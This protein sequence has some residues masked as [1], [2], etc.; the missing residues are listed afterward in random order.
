MD[1]RFNSTAGF[2]SEPEAI[3]ILYIFLFSDNVTKTMCAPAIMDLNYPLTLFISF[4]L[5]TPLCDEA[6]AEK[7]IKFD[8]TNEEKKVLSIPRVIFLFLPIKKKFE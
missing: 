5:V 2:V 7:K 3:E 1:N 4:N 8:K 6:C